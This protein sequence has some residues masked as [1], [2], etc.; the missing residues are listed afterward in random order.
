MALSNRAREIQTLVQSFHPLIVIETV[1]E[2]RVQALLQEATQ[3]MNMAMFE[4]SAPQGLARSPGGNSPWSQEYAPPGTLQTLDD[5]TQDPLELLRYIQSMNLRAVFWLK[6]FAQHLDEPVII[7][8]F[9][10]VVQLFS[11]HRSAIILSGHHVELPSDIACHQV[12]FDVKLPDRDELD[13]ITRKTLGVLKMKHRIQVQLE[14]GEQESLVQAL[15]GM[16][17]Q[18]A[19]QVLG[20]AAFDDGCLNGDDIQAILNRK[21][22][23]I[24]SASVLQYFPATTLKGDL[25]GFEGLKRWLDQARVGFSP[26]A[27]TWNLPT[28]KGILIVGI[29]GCGKSLAAKAI[30]RLWKMPLLKL[31]AGRIY[32]KYV[33]ESEKNFRQ[34]LTLAESMAPAILWIDELE[35]GFGMQKGDGD[36]GLSQRLFGSF[37]TWLQ[38]KTQEVFVVATANDISQ[39]PPELLRKGRFDEIFFVDLPDERDR[40]SILA[41][42]LKTHRQPLSQFDIDTLVKATVGFSGAELEQLVI[43]GLYRSLHLQ[44]TPDTALLLEQAQKIIPLSVSRREDLNQLRALAQERFMSVQ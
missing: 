12:Y 26:Q 1:E 9:R 6:D 31:E 40:A 30:A 8:H 39:L 3:D 41:I 15:S 10:E 18:Q 14:E 35:K 23:V 11:T 7:R 25:G 44:R 34:A 42:H 28:P 32:D 17:L 27:K 38:E 16:T 13:R 37:L 22:Q 2:E 33:G 21:A 20:Y 29:Q 24:R 5:R 43:A 4:W 36:G 19:T